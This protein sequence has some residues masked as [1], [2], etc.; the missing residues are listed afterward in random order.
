M[1]QPAMIGYVDAENGA[2]L[3]CTFPPKYGV[4]RSDGCGTQRKMAESYIRDV[5]Y[6]YYLPESYMLQQMEN[7][8]LQQLKSSPTTSF[9]FHISDV[10][11]RTLSTQHATAPLYTH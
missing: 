5:L 3:P 11:R 8:S 9:L 1:T 7:Q 10:D 6:E 4:A 2:S